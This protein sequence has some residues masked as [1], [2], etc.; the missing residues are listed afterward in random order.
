MVL[1]KVPIAITIGETKEITLTVLRASDESRRNLTGCTLHARIRA[2]LDDTGEPIFEAETDDG[3][4]HATQSG[5]TLGEAVLLI[6]EDV[7]SDLAEGNYVWDAWYTDALG[8]DQPLIAPS[9]CA[10][11]KGVWAP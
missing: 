9:L 5:E 7:T 6:G 2:D 1:R 10:V 11:T 4:T 3:I 8:R